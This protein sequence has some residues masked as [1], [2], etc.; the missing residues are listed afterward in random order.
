VIA[1]DKNLTCVTKAD[2]KAATYFST[3]ANELQATAMPPSAS[4]AAS[5]L[6][7]DAT[8]AARDFTKLSQA[9]TVRQ[10]QSTIAST[11]LQQT[12]NNFDQDYNTLGTTLTN[13]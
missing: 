10:Y 9:P 3:F 7:S 2:G 1:C 13:S 6:Y 8:T 12:L 5:R 11:R 4:A